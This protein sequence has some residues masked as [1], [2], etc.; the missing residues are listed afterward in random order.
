MREKL[1]R[2]KS[3]LDKAMEDLKLIGAFELLMEAAHLQALTC[4]RLGLLAERDRAAEHFL[5]AQRQLEASQ[6]LPVSPMSNLATCTASALDA[7]AC[8]A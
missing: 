8:E 4:N 3:Q 7:L 6:W 2:A 1:Q 5:Q